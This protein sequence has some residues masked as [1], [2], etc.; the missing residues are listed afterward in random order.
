MQPQA[1]AVVTQ[2]MLHCTVF[3]DLTRPIQFNALRCTIQRCCRGGGETAATPSHPVVR[4]QPTRAQDWLCTR[5]FES[6][7]LIRVGLG[8]LA[9]AAWRFCVCAS[10]ACQCPSTVASCKPAHRKG[11]QVDATRRPKVHPVGAGRGMGK[12]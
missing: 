5:S 6:I 9:P 7:H 8:H 12:G 11:S 1:L 3:V 10:M 4:P 2:G